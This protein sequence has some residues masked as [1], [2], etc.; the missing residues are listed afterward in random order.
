LMFTL[1]ASP[2]LWTEVSKLKVTLKVTVI[3]TLLSAF[4]FNNCVASKLLDSCYFRHNGGCS[5]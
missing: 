2:L 5:T 3:L 4:G 1:K